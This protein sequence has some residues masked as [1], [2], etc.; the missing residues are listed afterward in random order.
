MLALKLTAGSPASSRAP[1]LAPPASPSGRKLSATTPGPTV[2][3]PS[4]TN[5][6]Y[7]G[8]R[9]GSVCTNFTCPAATCAWV[10]ASTGTPGF[11]ASSKRPFSRLAMKNTSEGG[12]S[13]TSV[14]LMFAPESTT[15]PPA[16]ISSATAPSTGA[17]FTGVT[18]SVTFALG[19]A[20][21]PPAPVLPRS[22]RL[23]VNATGALPSR[24]VV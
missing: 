3:T 20:S 12:A 22:F 16:E 23:A 15:V 18:F 2:D 17:S 1:L 8:G 11:P 4:V 7:D 24:T 21:G 14:A 6:R 5:T 19:E 9:S 13:S 10:N